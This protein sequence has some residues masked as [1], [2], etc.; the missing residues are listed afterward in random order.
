GRD[1]A[2]L[3]AQAAKELA[4]RESA[5][6][7]EHAFGHFDLM[8]EAR[9]FDHVQHRPART[10]LGI[11]WPEHEPAET[12]E[13]N[14]AG[15]HRAGLERDI[16]RRVG[17]TP[18]AERRARRPDRQNLGVRGRVVR[19]FG[20]IVPAPEDAAFEHDHRPDRHL[21]LFGGAPRL[22]ER[23]AHPPL[24]LVVGW[25]RAGRVGFAASAPFAAARSFAADEAR[26]GHFAR[27]GNAVPSGAIARS[28]TS[29]K[30]GGPYT[31]LA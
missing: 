15:A 10:E 24:V 26:P 16:D 17:E 12:A 20:A 7:S 27:F 21:S 25:R 28:T 2:A 6:V 30:S 11:T 14:R 5:L 4:Q 19:R 18:V 31:P 1:L 22:V 29:G 3:L 9:R 13:L 8:V 23:D